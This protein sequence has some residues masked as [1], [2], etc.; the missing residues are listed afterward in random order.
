MMS[1][2]VRRVGQLSTWGQRRR[3]SP[4]ELDRLL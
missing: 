4:R 3:W 1:L 2:V